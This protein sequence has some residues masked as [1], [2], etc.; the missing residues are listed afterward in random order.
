MERF[1]Q[2]QGWTVL[3]D[4]LKDPSISLRRKAAF[5]IQSLFMHTTSPDEAQGYQRA[6][7][8][9]GIH[10]TLI[11]SLSQDTALPAGADG[12]AETIDLD[13]NEKALAA[14]V[15]IVQTAGQGSVK[16]C[17]EQEELSRLSSLLSEVERDGRVP[18]DVDQ[19]A[20]ISFTAA[21]AT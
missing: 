17:F 15:T 3:V 5:L 11:D 16:Q 9:A 4:A 8:S 14:L 20:W 21:V 10:T 7:H 12:D 2:L 18:V 6:A 1:E 13:Y 19:K